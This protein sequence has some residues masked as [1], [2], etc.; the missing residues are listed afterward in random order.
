[1]E[2]ELG[3]ASEIV[4]ADVG[5]GLANYKEAV[6]NILGNIFN[7]LSTHQGLALIFILIV[8]GIIIWLIVSPRKFRKQ[9]ENKLSSKDKEIAKKDAL[10]EDQ[11][12]KLTVL[13]KKLADQQGVVSEALLRTLMTLTGYDTDRLQT[14]FKS[15]TRISE[16]P[17][18]IADPQANTVPESRLLEDDSDESTED[19][20][21]ST[22]DND[23]KEKKAS[24]T[25]PDEVL[26]TNQGGE[27]KL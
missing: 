24:S 3:T 5:G 14:F 10:I 4:T 12:T 9:M 23:A 19:S 2:K 21:D 8:L 22:E 7:W 18:Q 16:N 11:K 6:Y 15:L 25:G 13:Q 26:E 20:D 17:L 1:M 27:K